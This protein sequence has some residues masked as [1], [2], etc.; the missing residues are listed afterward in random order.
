[1]VETRY[2]D[3]DI[4]DADTYRL[5]VPCEVQTYELTGIGTEDASDRQTPDPRDNLYFSIDEL[6]AYRLSRRYQA[7]GTPVSFLKY[8]ELPDGSAQKRIVE[9]TRTLYFDDAGLT[10][11]AA[12][13]FGQH[14]PRGLKYEDYKLALTKDLLDKVFGARLNQSPIPPKTA[15]DLLNDPAVSGYWPGENFVDNLRGQYWMRSGIAGFAPNA[16]RHFFLPERYADPF[17]NPTTVSFDAYDLFIESTQD[18]RGNEVKVVDFDFRVL[19]PAAMR[20]LNE[21]VTRIAVDIL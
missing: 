21:N 19:S 8:H 20:D 16:W 4:D 3:A 5:R 15:R 6:R 7:S 12:L 11:T 9:H 17:G 18:A 14:G 10:P 13:P 2:T 1:Y